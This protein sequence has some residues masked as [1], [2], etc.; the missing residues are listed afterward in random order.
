MH[1][2]CFKLTALRCATTVILDGPETTKRYVNGRGRIIKEIPL[3]HA[4]PEQ[5]WVPSAFNGP[6]GELHSTL[7]GSG[8]D[9]FEHATSQPL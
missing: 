5:A 7:E 4:A 1:M 3:F 8:A 9:P 2:T 6:P